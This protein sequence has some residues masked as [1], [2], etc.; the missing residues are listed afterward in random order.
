[1]TTTNI[2]PIEPTSIKSITSKSYIQYEK[3]FCYL[4]CLR[5][6]KRPN[7][8]IVSLNYII[9]KF[10]SFKGPLCKK[11]IEKKKKGTLFFYFRLFLS[12]SSV[13]DPSIANVQYPPPPHCCPFL[14]SKLLP[15]IPVPIQYSVILNTL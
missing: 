7:C 14:P 12:F 9:C 2:L 1:M 5:I 3:T 11:I 13:N 6:R 4:I 15:R 8:Q 10:V